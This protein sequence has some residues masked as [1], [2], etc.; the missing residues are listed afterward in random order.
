MVSYAGTDGD[1]VFD[2]FATNAPIN[3]Y[4]RLRT[5]HMRSLVE[6]SEAVTCHATG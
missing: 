4:Y 6:H 2:P 5:V 1:K 3:L